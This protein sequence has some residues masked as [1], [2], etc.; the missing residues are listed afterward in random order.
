MGYQEKQRPDYFDMREALRLS[1]ID[2]PDEEIRK[3]CKLYLLADIQADLTDLIMEIEDSF[4]SMTQRELL[5]AL[6]FIKDTL[7]QYEKEAY[8]KEDDDE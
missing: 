8:P 6:Q 3:D 5:F 4:N 1:G 7:R 2:K